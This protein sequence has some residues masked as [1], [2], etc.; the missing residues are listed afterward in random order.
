MRRDVMREQLKTEYRSK[1][2][3]ARTAVRMEKV[4]NV[5]KSPYFPQQNVTNILLCHLHVSRSRNWSIAFQRCIFFKY[6]YIFYNYNV[7]KLINILHDFI[8]KK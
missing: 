1:C 2:G 6:E 8:F 4:S 7:Y 3:R 5:R